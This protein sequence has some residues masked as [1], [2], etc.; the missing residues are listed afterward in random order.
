M[1]RDTLARA[2]WPLMELPSIVTD[3][4]AV[5]GRTRPLEQHHIVWRSQGRLFRDGRE[6]PK[7]T[8]TLCGFGNHLRDSDGRLL[9][10]GM[11]HHHMLHFRNSGGVLEYLVTAGPVRYMEALRSDGWSPIGGSGEL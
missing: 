3:R 5:C 7:P 6:V 9:C 8:I 2:Y 11:A 10:H 4:C 1:P